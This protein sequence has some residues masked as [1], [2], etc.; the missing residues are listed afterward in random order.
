[1]YTLCAHIFMHFAEPTLTQIEA[2]GKVVRSAERNWASPNK[3]SP[4]WPRW[5]AIGRIRTML[6]NTLHAQ[7]LDLRVSTLNDRGQR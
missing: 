2:I 1:M 7:G 3:R 5:R 6:L 4:P